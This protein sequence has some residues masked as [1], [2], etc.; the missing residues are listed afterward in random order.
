MTHFRSKFGSS[1]TKFK[2]KSPENDP[3]NHIFN[4]FSFFDLFSKKF[5][6]LISPDWQFKVNGQDGI[7]KR[8][9]VS[10]NDIKDSFDQ[11]QCMEDNLE[12]LENYSRRNNVKILGIQEDK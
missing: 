3:E 4:V 7:M 2:I 10:E 8:H 6:L 12:N 9:T 5:L 11:I 1:L